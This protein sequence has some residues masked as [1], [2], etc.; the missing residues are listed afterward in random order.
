LNKTFDIV[1]TSY[2]TIGWLPDLN[3]WAA[4]VAQCLKPGGTFLIIDF[5]PVL[6]MLDNEMKMLQY[7]Y[8]NVDPIIETNLGSYADRNAVIKTTNIGWNHSL[9]DIITALIDNGLKLE[10][11]S[12][13]DYSNYNCFKNTVQIDN[14][15]YQIKNLQGVLPMM[16]AIKC[17]K[18]KLL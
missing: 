1:Y 3:K 10:K 5:H 17:S 18:P 4:V 6:W 9:S 15:K 13:F 7:P 2:G 8:F 14:G 11:F 16:Y 12:E